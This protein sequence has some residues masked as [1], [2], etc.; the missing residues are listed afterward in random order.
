MTSEILTINSSVTVSNFRPGIEELGVHVM[1][2]GPF[3]QDPIF[4]LLPRRPRGSEGNL[5]SL[6]ALH[7]GTVASERGEV[8][9]DDEIEAAPRR[10]D[11][12]SLPR[13]EL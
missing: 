1:E 2:K 11:M 8:R 13:V 7:G 4:F 12:S 6:A 3:K 10:Q 9:A 5:S